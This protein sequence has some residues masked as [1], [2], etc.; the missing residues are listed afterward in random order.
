MDVKGALNKNQEL[1]SAV[2]IVLKHGTNDGKL[3]ESCFTLY[4]RTRPH[5]AVVPYDETSACYRER[6]EE[7]IIEHY[8]RY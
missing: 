1:L 6:L 2:K 7:Y 8:Y 3:L 4:F 5:I